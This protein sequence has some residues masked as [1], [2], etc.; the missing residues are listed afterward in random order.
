MY[1]PNRFK[2]VYGDLEEL[3]SNSSVA[4]VYCSHCGEWYRAVPNKNGD[5]IAGGRMVYSYGRIDLLCFS[6]EDD[7][8]FY[9]R[10]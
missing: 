6:C 8:N 5:W 10:D 7:M 3:S 4:S 9:E 2:K 1:N